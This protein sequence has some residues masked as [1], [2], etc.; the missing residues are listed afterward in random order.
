VAT[1]WGFKVR[2]DTDV[3]VTVQICRRRG[4]GGAVII[5]VVSM[6][7]SRDAGWGGGQHGGVRFTTREDC[8]VKTDG[9][10]HVELDWGGGEA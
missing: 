8:V 3:A 1:L 5:Q 4:L 2:N 10:V 6:A 9:E 7:H